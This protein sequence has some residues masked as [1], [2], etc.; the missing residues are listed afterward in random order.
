[1]YERIK[2][3]CLKILYNST[4]EILSVLVKFVSRFYNETERLRN[5]EDYW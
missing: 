3:K 4:D 5:L 1:M 2:N